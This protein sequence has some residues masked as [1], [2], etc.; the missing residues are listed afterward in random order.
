MIL[1]NGKVIAETSF[2]MQNLS[3][4]KHTFSA[5]KSIISIAIGILIDMKK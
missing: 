5:C 4:P 1:R 3:I 2:G